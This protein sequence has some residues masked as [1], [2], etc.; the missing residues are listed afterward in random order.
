MRGEDAD[1]YRHKNFKRIDEIIEIADSKL[2]KFK[3]RKP[4]NNHFNLA[5]IGILI[6][7][8]SQHLMNEVMN[9]GVDVYYTDTDSIHIKKRDVE[10]LS[11][12]FKECFGRELL[13]ENLGEFKDEF[14][15]FVS[16]R[17]IFTGRKTYVDQLVSEDGKVYHYCRMKGVSVNAICNAANRR[18]PD[19]NPVAFNDASG[20][21]ESA[22]DKG[23]DYSIFKLYEDLYNGESITF[24]LVDDYNPR[25][26]LH[27]NETISSKLHFYRTLSFATSTREPASSI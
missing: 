14:R 2:I 10:T 13:G 21:F 4:L 12:A 5:P 20:H 9:L 19:A 22:K 27:K 25:F 11:I 3:V 17:S 7:S 1:A 15:G 6:V 16:Q 18:F 24:D 8:M 23:S 26:Q